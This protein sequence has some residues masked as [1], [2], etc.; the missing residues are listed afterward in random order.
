MLSNE[1]ES[2]DSGQL[3]QTL[4]T[5]WT[6]ENPKKMHQIGAG[7]HER[8]TKSYKWFCFCIWLVEQPAWVFLT[9]HGV[10]WLKATVSGNG[11]ALTARRRVE[12]SRT[13]ESGE[14][15]AYNKVILHSCEGRTNCLTVSICCL[16]RLTN[17]GNPLTR[18]TN[19]SS[20]KK[21]C[22]RLSV[23]TCDYLWYFAS[24]LYKTV[25]YS[26]SRMIWSFSRP[27]ESYS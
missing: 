16:Y 26:T 22:H 21:Y 20:H 18:W 12:H 23:I 5:Q 8:R 15:Q 25:T 17:F 27:M 3:R 1:N 7:K 14:N 13:R 11:P 2:N 6:N 19:V 24:F 9:N 10:R 4:T